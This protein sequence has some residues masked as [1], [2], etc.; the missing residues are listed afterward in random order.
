[1]KIK[2][3][4]N[5]MHLFLIDEEAEIK[6]KDYL[7]DELT[8]HYAGIHQHSGV[9]YK[10]KDKPNIIQCVSGTTCPINHSSKVIAYYPLTEEAKELDLPILPPF[11]KEIEEDVNIKAEKYA[12]RV[13]N[14]FSVSIPANEL[15]KSSK[16]DFIAGYK[17]AQ[18]KQFSLDD[19]INYSNWLSQWLSYNKYKK[20]IDGA[21]PYGI[22]ELISNKDLI[23]MFVAGLP[24][25]NPPLNQET[26]QSLSTQQLPVGFIPEPNDIGFMKNTDIMVGK[27]LYDKIMSHFKTITN[28]EGKEEIQGKYVW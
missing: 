2:L 23:K 16:R 1:M 27:K 8:S 24:S 13:Q 28:L 21:K 6:E 17:A 12:W 26:I 4:S 19:V 7:F 9:E 10:N 3:I 15:V 22:G 18:S 5:G 11:K 14:D 20:V 25:S